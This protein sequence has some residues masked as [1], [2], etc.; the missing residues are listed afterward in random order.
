[1]QARHFTNFPWQCLI[2]V[3]D[4]VYE[5]RASDTALSCVR[6]CIGWEHN[7]FPSAEQ[8]VWLAAVASAC[9]RECGGTVQVCTRSWWVLRAIP[10]IQPGQLIALPAAARQ[11]YCGIY[12]ASTCSST[13]STQPEQNKRRETRAANTRSWSMVPQRSNVKRAR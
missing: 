11:C 7:K 8:T 2:S 3:N 4:Y 1:M 13:Q 12:L 10:A 6:R 5:D 9:R